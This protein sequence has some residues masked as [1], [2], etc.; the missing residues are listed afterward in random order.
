MTRYRTSIAGWN[1]VRPPP[2]GHRRRI[3]RSAS[4]RLAWGVWAGKEV[5]FSAS[6][7]IRYDA[8]SV[9][10]PHVV[11]RKSKRR[12]PQRLIDATFAPA[13]G[14][15]CGGETERG[16][17]AEITAVAL[18]YPM[19]DGVGLV[20][21]RHSFHRGYSKAHYLLPSH[22]TIALREHPIHRAS[23]WRFLRT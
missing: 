7:P 8:Y 23:K 12:L 22:N 21:P 6:W 10:M 19:R 5:S 14:N 9:L 15:S 1:A 18:A 17:G 3:T 13:T 11:V 20:H 16:D 4:T 2:D